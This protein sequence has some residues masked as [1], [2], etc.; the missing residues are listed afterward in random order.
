MLTGLGDSDTK[1]SRLPIT[2][3]SRLAV[4]SFLMLFTELGLIRWASEN[5]L[6]LSF[7]SNLILVASFLGIGIGFLRAHRERQPLQWAPVALASL[8]AFFVL[9]PARQTG[10][11]HGV[12]VVGLFTWPALPGWVEVP[13]LFLASAAVMSLI[14]GGVART[15][16][17]FEP[18]K[19]Y[20][21]DISGSLAGIAAF[22]LLAF[23]DAPP[24]AWALIIA[25][26]F[27]AVL[28]PRPGRAAAVGMVLLIVV[29]GV[30]SFWP[31]NS[32][33]PYNRITISK[34][35]APGELAI[36]ANGR[37]HQTIVPVSR[38]ATERPYYLFPYAYAPTGGP[39]RVLI[40]G[41]GS[42]T[43]VALALAEGA[44]H[45]D[46]VEIDPVLYN[47]GLTRNPD[48]PYQD[49]R[50]QIHINDGR[51]F[52][53]ETSQ[54]YNMILL[55][56]PDSLTLV[57]GQGSLRLES[58]LFT[59]Q[60]IQEIRDHLAPGGV[61][62]MY[63]YYSPV[64][65]K[66][67]V[68]TLEYVFGQDPCLDLGP[69]GAGLRQMATL[70]VAPG[71][72]LKCAT[73]APSLPANDLATDDH[74]FPYLAGRSIPPLYLITI[75]LILLASLFLVRLSSGPIRQ[76]AGYLDLF[77]MGAAF[78]LLETKSVVQFALL[79][80]TTWLV[81]SLVF[82]GVLLSVLAAVT[83]ARRVR[84]PRPWILYLA[85]LISLAVAWA[86]PVESLLSLPFWPRFAVAVVIAFA[87]IFFANLV[88]ADRFRDV[89]SSTVAFGAN[90]LGAMVGGVLEYVSLITG[91]RALL[92]VVAALYGLAFLTGRRHLS[93]R[94]DLPSPKTIGV[95]RP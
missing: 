20:W 84:L 28:G 41:A 94:G 57:G 6:Y 12:I 88:F 14:A 17:E 55:A 45:V 31:N 37:P 50:V 27:L 1:I 63:N 59:V 75:A 91:Y 53:Q 2:G 48:H 56:L 21:L 49:P 46:A 5:V 7:F 40:I 82:A 86:V 4:L 47:I 38:I 71:H 54:K 32:W 61:F 92:I 95:A 30:E 25:A 81:N 66:R 72:P 8:V 33:S 83:L 23:L 44:S 62:S 67:N 22:S 29:L 51:A 19:A 9:L 26:G 79:F 10:S 60:A 70:T 36:A 24:L 18:L 85:L 58:Y 16:S 68:A 78:L 65:Y 39:G 35:S 77:F 64:A 89:A 34:L 76:M 3:R 13:I 80:G 73:T 15:F 93:L 43:D 42:G 11:P 90:L 69:A 87:P 74:P 52:L